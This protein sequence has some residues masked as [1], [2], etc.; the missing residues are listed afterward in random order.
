M[1][2]I[3]VD[4]RFCRTDLA[5]PNRYLA[6]IA[7]LVGALL[8]S[9]PA[10]ARHICLEPAS[11][12]FEAGD[13]RILDLEDRI[14]RVLE[15]G[16]HQVT[17]SGSVRIITDGVTKEWGAVFDP[18]TGQRDAEKVE[19]YKRELAKAYREELGCMERVVVSVVGLRAHFINGIATWDGVE[20]SV[21]TEARNFTM[22]FGGGVEWGW[23][24]VLS[25]WVRVLDLE[26]ESV[27]FRSSGIEPLVHMSIARNLDKLPVDQWLRNQTNLTHA[28]DNALGPGGR[29]LDAARSTT[30]SPDSK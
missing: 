13:E 3:S 1:K 22:A 25:L 6:M 5:V 28:I 23:I 4:R 21:S 7:S 19:T 15:A 10:D 2:N 18:I 12:P 9:T 11:L 8:S 29:L 14:V 30:K 17:T 24:S 20:M 27:A 26:G 16:D